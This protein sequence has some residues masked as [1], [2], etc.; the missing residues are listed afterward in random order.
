MSHSAMSIS[1]CA[2][3][4]CGVPSVRIRAH[5]ASRSGN[6]APITSGSTHR[7]VSPTARSNVCE[8]I[9]AAPAMPSSPPAVVSLR[10]M[11]AM[12]CSVIP[13]AQV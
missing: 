9:I 12:Y 7:K 2:C 3:G 11:F 4:T 8:E 1:D 5:T 10:M 13:S 6:V